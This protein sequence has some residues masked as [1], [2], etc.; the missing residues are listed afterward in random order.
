MDDVHAA[1][2]TAGIVEEPLLSNV[3]LGVDVVGVVL[4]QL[5]DNVLDDLGGVV[6]V[7]LDAAQGQVVQFVGPEDVE[8]LEVALQQVVDGR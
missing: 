2:R 1:H 3:P 6:A 4:V 5:G 7:G 8:A